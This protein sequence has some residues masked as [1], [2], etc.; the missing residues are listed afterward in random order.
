VLAAPGLRQAIPTS[1]TAV[2]VGNTATSNVAFHRS[3]LVLLTRAP[4]LPE[5]G[6]SADDRM[7]VQDPR[8]GLA[9]EVAVY[10]QYRR[11]R[12]EIGIA[13][14]VQNVKSE[15]SALLIG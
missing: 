12:Y 4:A 3:A 14:G 15:H 7:V 5:E 11:V 6:D 8:S 13:W 9:F 2:T 10:A 1:A